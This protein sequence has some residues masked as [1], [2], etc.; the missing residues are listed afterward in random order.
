MANGEIDAL[1]SRSFERVESVW[2]VTVY[3]VRELFCCFDDA[4]NSYMMY[5]VN[6]QAIIVDKVFVIAVNKE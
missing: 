3:V 2:S 5:N 4:S 1:P 6:W